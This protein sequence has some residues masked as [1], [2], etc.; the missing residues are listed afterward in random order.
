M[1]ILIHL[2]LTFSFLHEQEVKFHCEAFGRQSNIV[3]V[4]KTK[5]SPVIKFLFFLLHII[6]VSFLAGLQLRNLTL[7]YCARTKIGVFV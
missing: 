2:R 5:D 3:K 1:E 4:T 6:T 7:T